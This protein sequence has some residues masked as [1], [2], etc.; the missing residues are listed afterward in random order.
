MVRLSL[1]M[2]Q[3]VQCETTFS[4]RLLAYFVDLKGIPEHLP[5]RHELPQ[6]QNRNLADV[7][8]IPIAYSRATDIVVSGS[9]FAASQ[10]F[11]VGIMTQSVPRDST[12]T[13]RPPNF[14]DTTT[15]QLL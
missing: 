3:V 10:P 5:T 13:H 11:L 9:N 2:T 1:N 15:H 8:S 6:H 14:G 12:L 4:E 7:F